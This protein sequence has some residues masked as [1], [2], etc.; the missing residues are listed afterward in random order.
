MIYPDTWQHVSI[1]ECCRVISGSTPRRNK[2]EY[3]NG[4]IHWVTPKD[5]SNL[6]VPILKEAPEKITKIGYKSCSTTLLPKGSILF[7]SRAPIGL[8]AIA[9]REMCTNQGFKSLVPNESVDSS[10]L[11]WCIRYFTPQ[12]AAQGSGT[13]FKELSKTI[14]E[15]FKIPLPPLE[16]QKRIAAILDKADA[17]RRKRKKAIA[18]TEE[19]LRSTFLDMFGDPVTNP[20]GWKVVELEKI[21][22]ESFQ[23]GAY[24]PKDKYSNSEG[25]IEMVHM[26]D[27]FY[28]VAKPGNLKRVLASKK[29]REQYELTEGDVLINRRSLNYEGSAKPCL[30]PSLKESLIFESSLIR[31]RVNQK[32]VDPIFFYSYMLQPR[33]RAAFVFPYVTKSTI[34]GINQAGLKRV[35][36]VVP[37]IN[38]QLK[39][40]QIYNQITHTTTNNKNDLKQID[41]LFNSLLQ[42]AFRGEL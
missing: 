36:I 23:N 14:V 19:L 12:L 24:F 39:Y 22:G 30:I 9:G 3:W 28:G 13:T 18:L 38:L 25:S 41:N 6:N 5:L 42:K 10:Y 33:A 17:I 32:I 8:V 15:K 34:S 7:S 16:E 40:K 31:V 11:Y 26:S 20:K 2:P 1:K 37:P 29:E 21:L 35:K 4:G 27:A